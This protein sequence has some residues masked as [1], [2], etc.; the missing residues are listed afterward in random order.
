MFEFRFVDHNQIVAMSS[1]KVLRYSLQLT[2]LRKINS[3]P[4]SRRFSTG[5]H[6]FRRYSRIVGIAGAGI[7]SFIAYGFTSDS[8]AYAY[9]K[10]KVSKITNK[11]LLTR[12]YLKLRTSLINNNNLCKI[13]CASRTI[14]I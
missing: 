13:H 1:S 5:S 9:S 3:V 2:R 12:R 10:K 7:L 6:L 11:P 4:V 14:L 8:K